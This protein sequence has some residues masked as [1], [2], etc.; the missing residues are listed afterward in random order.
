MLRRTERYAD[1]FARHGWDVS[2]PDMVQTLSVAEL[3]ELLPGHDGWSIGDDPACPRVV[4]AGAAG[5]VRVVVKW[6][7]GRGQRG[8]R[9]F[10]PSG[11]CPW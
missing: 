3:V 8:L 7:G 5:R 6:G 2:V 11:G 1:E 9:R 4:E 10:R